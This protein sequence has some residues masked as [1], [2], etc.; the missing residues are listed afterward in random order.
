MDSQRHPCIHPC[1]YASIQTFCWVKWKKADLVSWYTI[2]SKIKTNQHLSFILDKKIKPLFNCA[3]Q[4]WTWDCCQYHPHGQHVEMV[5]TSDREHL[6]AF[7]KWKHVKIWDNEWITIRIYNI[8]FPQLQN[9]V[10][11]QAY[12]SSYLVWDCR[13][14]VCMVRFIMICQE[15]I[16]ICWRKICIMC[17]GILEEYMT[18][19][20]RIF[21]NAQ[22]SLLIYHFFFITYLFIF[23]LLLFICMG[24]M[25]RCVC[26]CRMYHFLKLHCKFITW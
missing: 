20:K 2:N 4:S 6:L 18:W 12:I 5:N 7:S 16:L 23:W 10:F 15:V 14:T 8:Y 13:D 9:F 1:I 22:Y 19:C 26:V 21:Y 11:T 24:G 25:H 3:E 17:N